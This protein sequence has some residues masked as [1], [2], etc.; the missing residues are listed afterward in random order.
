[1]PP[2]LFTSS[3]ASSAPICFKMPW[4]AQGPDSGASSAILTSFGCCP[5]ACRGASA[6]AAPASPSLIAVRR[7]NVEGL[8]IAVSLP[9]G[10]DSLVVSRF[11]Q[12]E[13]RTADPIVREQGPVRPFE[14]DVARLEHIAMIGALERLGHA[15]L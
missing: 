6:P 2:L 8:L 5:R 4:R 13:V 7:P 15:L 11:H 1:M 9:C 3:T 12:A 14:N 10:C